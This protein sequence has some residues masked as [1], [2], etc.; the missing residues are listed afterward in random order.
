MRGA[1]FFF[2]ARFRVWGLGR[3]A[4]TPRAHLPLIPPSPPPRTHLQPRLGLDEIGQAGARLAVVLALQERHRLKVGRRRGR[5]GCV[6]GVRGARGHDGAGAAS[7]GDQARDDGQEQG[8]ARGGG[9]RGPGVC[10]CRERSGEREGT[11]RRG[12]ADWMSKTH[13]S[14]CFTKSPSCPGFGGGRG[15]WGRARHGGRHGHARNGGGG[16]RESLARNKTVMSESFASRSLS[17]RSRVAVPSL[18]HAPSTVA[19]RSRPGT[20]IRLCSISPA[21]EQHARF[22]RPLRDPPRSETRAACV[23]P[24]CA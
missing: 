10:G 12:R 13:S 3:T 1:R 11:R 6:R 22:F 20:H 19:P 17:R 9:G 15:G 18:V 24:L 2:E 7:Q 14:L 23:R 5:G 4:P 21:P 16:T 8:P